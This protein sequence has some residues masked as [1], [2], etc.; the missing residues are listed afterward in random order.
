MTARTVKI[1]LVLLLP[2]LIICQ[3]AQEAGATYYKYRDGRGEV[4]ITNKLES[5]PIKYR[6]TVKVINDEELTRKDWGARKQANTA[7]PVAEESPARK[8]GGDTASESP[9]GRLAAN[10][11]WVKLLAIVCGAVA[12]FLIVA[13]LVSH[14]PS[15]QLARLVCLVYFFSIFLFV[16][17]TYADHLVDGYFTIKKKV[18]TMFR[19]ANERE[20]LK[21]DEK[22]ADGGGEI[23]ADR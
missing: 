19:K 6:S 5:V 3:A 9:F 15:P 12:G 23:P 8:P 1:F 7:P 10:Y 13:K 4:C 18:V 21:P 20:G 22:P 14:L 16:Y 2:V 17:K 11:P